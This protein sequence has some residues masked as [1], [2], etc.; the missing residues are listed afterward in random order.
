M[1]L[2]LAML[3]QCQTGDAGATCPIGQVWAEQVTVSA[4][5]HNFGGFH[6]AMQTASQPRFLL[7]KINLSVEIAWKNTQFSG[8][9][10]NSATSAQFFGLRLISFGREEVLAEPRRRGFR[11]WRP[12]GTAGRPVHR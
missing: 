4:K 6:S 8:F 7:K 11:R 5:N 1:S 2:R 12:E 3:G 10:P 9:Y